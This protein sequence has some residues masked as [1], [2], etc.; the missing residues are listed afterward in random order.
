MTSEERRQL[1]E[2]ALERRLRVGL[3]DPETTDAAMDELVRRS[4]RSHGA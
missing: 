1:R 2:E 4:I 3:L